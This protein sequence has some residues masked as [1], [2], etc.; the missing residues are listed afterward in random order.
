MEKSWRKRG[1][2]LLNAKLKTRNPTVHCSRREVYKMRREKK[3][4]FL[5]DD[6][7]TTIEK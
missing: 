3:T 2:T 6:C 5:V 7:S 4:S 1:Y